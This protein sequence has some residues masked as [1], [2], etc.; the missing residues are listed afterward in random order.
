MHIHNPY[1]SRPTH[2]LRGSLHTH[3]TNS[4]GDRAPQTV[5]DSYAEAGYGFLMISDH[6]RFTDPDPLDDRGMVLIPGY[7]LSAHA[8]HVLHLNTRKELDP[9]HDRADAIQTIVNDEGIAVACHPNW[10]ESFNHCDQALLD[11]WNGYAGI[12]IVN[13]VCCIFPGSGYA[14]DRWDLLLGAGRRVWGF[15]NDDA[16]T[17]EHQFMAWNVVWCAERTLEAVLDALRTGSFYASTGVT[18]ESIHVDPQARTIHV[19]APNA[20]A[21][22]VYADYQ[23]RLV[24]H[25]GASYTFTVPAECTR[26]YVRF[27]CLGEG[28][29]AAWTQ[30][31]F[32]TQET[33]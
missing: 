26:R 29:S 14:L 5:V 30:P 15:A 4:D 2:V 23:T 31:F 10:L 28:G 11:E 32:L 25:K 33:N 19:E 1:P 21:I 20:Q 16:H 6:D 9:S 3:T 7:E 13:G 27:E 12:E 17:V 24:F 8:P 22:A 18:I